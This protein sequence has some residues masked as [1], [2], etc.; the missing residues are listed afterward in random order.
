MHSK[1]AVSQLPP[2][3]VARVSM[4]TF[5]NICEKWQLST[6]EAMLLLGRPSRATFFK[7]KRETAKKLTDDQLTRIS[8]V[9]GVYKALRVLFPTEQQ[10]NAWINKPNSYFDGKPAREQFCSGHILSMINLRRYLDAM[11]G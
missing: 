7:W 6:E 5:F 2:E 1:T 8:L 9:L 4:K 3:E 11:R 10:A